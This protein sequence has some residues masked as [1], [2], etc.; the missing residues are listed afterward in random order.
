MLRWSGLVWVRKGSIIKRGY[1]FKNCDVGRWCSNCRSTPLDRVTWN[2]TMNFHCYRWMYFCYIYLSSYSTLLTLHYRG[3]MERTQVAHEWAKEKGISYRVGENGRLRTLSGQVPQVGFGNSPPVGGVA[4][5]VP[6]H[7][8]VRAEIGR[9]YVPPRPL[10]QCTW[11][12]TWG[13]LIC[14]GTSG[15][16]NIQKRD[17]RYIP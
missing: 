17:E 5:N 14:H 10:G 7:C 4:W 12:W 13:R 3:H 16:S 9:M 11:T 1:G 2:M 8:R 15:L 6:S